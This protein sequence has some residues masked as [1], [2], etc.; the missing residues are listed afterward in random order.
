M[1][2]GALPTTAAEREE[3]NADIRARRAIP[4]DVTAVLPSIARAGSEFVPLDGLRTALSQFGATLGFRPSIDVDAAELY[5]NAMS[6]C[7]VVPTLIC[8]LWRLRQGLEPIAPHASLA[9]AANYLYMMQG[10]EPISPS[11]RPRSRST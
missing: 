3:F 8:A 9:Y 11:T 7:A 5:D 6:T 1:F 4:A 10:D 2:R